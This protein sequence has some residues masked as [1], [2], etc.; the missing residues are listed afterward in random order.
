MVTRVELLHLLTRHI[1]SRAAGSF[2][3]NGAPGS[4]KSYGLTGLAQ[5][6]PDEVGGR[7]VVLGPYAPTTVAQLTTSI[8]LD[9]EAASYLSEPF[10]S[11]VSTDLY[12]MWQ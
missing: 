9:L 1:R 4:G 2:F 12:E 7:L 8:R 10:P 5:Q 3:I 11:E 6:L